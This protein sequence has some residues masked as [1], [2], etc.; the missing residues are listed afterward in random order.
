LKLIILNPLPRYAW[1]YGSSLF[2]ATMLPHFLT[3]SFIVFACQYVPYF[4]SHN[5]K[6]HHF[7][8]VLDVVSI[9]EFAVSVVE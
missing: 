6:D 8:Q 2:T 9:P 7:T 4:Q 1:G 3:L 5:T